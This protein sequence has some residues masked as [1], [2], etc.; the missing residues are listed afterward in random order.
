MVLKELTYQERTEDSETLEASSLTAS[1]LVSL[2]SEGAR[3]VL[4]S[5]TMQTEACGKKGLRLRLLESRSKF[6]KIDSYG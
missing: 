3:Q 2:V 5:V 1:H 6:W 4:F